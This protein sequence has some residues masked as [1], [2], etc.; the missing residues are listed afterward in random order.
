MLAGKKL[1]SACADCLQQP[2][3]PHPTLP[4]AVPSMERSEKIVYNRD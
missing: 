2:E 1:A 4:C 3:F